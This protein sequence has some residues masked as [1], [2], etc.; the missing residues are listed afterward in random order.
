M[1]WQLLLPALFVVLVSLSAADSD[2]S[3]DEVYY[4]PP[5][6]PAPLYGASM[7]QTPQRPIILIPGTNLVSLYVSLFVPFSQICPSLLGSS[8]VAR[9]LVIQ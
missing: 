5:R 9:S 2:L 7:W 3:L 8:F 4:C 1:R 6:A